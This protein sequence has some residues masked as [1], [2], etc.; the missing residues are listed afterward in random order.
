MTVP[1]LLPF[2]QR[3]ETCERDGFPLVEIDG[4]LYCSVEWADSL[5]GGQRV[6]G[7]SEGAD[8]QIELLMTG[9]HVFP[10][11]C[12]CCGARFTCASA[13]SVKC[14]R[15][16]WAA[17]SRASATASGSVPR[18]HRSATRSLPS[19]SAAPRSAKIARSRCRWSR[20][21]EFGSD[22]RRTSLSVSPRRKEHE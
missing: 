19:S 22:R 12:P 17:Q 20:C 14:V 3:V 16:C 15:F 1:P 8:G 2:L 18:S 10:I 11:T 21:G 6:L 7:V 5:V 9:D 4:D 13:R